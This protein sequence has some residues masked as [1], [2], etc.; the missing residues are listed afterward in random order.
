MSLATARRDI[1]KRLADNWGTTAIAYDN[2]DFSPPQG[3]AWIRLALLD[4][5]AF[6]VTIG[7]PGTHRQTGIILLMIFVPLSEGT[8]VVRQYA[9]TLSAL[10]RDVQFN[11]ITCREA[12]P[13]N[14]GAVEGWYQYHV[15]IPYF[16]DSVFTT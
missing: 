2:V 1:E 8:H 4:G 13:V 5:D 3:A 15:N 11:G 10:F 7:N 16:Y 6:R 14:V 9:D 12:S